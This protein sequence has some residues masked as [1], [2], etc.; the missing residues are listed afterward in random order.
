LAGA[1]FALPE[2]VEMLRTPV[3]AE[4]VVVLAASDPANVYTLPLAPGAE[5]DPLA[6]PRGAG[7]LLVTRAGRIVLVAEGRGTKLRVREGASPAEVTEAVGALVGRL[8]ARRRAGRARDVVVET[9]DGER[10]AGSRYADAMREA[11]FKGMGTG[12]RYYAGI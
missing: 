3:V 10:A 2:A 6:K 12:L 5:S 8:M 9:I 1:Q 11:G 4:D 7:A